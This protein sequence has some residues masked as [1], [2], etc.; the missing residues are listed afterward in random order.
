MQSAPPLPIAIF[1]QNFVHFTFAMR[2]DFTFLC[3]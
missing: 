1:K 2:A 3:V